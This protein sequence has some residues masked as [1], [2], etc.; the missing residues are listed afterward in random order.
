MS[1]QASTFR[2][3]YATKTGTKVIVLRAMDSEVMEAWMRALQ[4]DIK[5]LHSDDKDALS[6]YFP[7]LMSW[8]EEGGEG[9]VPIYI[10]L[11]CLLVS[12]VC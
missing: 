11:V 5:A 4:D 6:K 8:W 1:T 9:R 3:K 10:K 7:L 2:I 12:L